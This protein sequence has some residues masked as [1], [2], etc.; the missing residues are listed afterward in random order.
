MGSR[1][2][3]RGSRLAAR[4]SWLRLAGSHICYTLKRHILSKRLL[5]PS[6]NALVVCVIRILH[7]I[8]QAIKKH[9]NKTVFGNQIYNSILTCLTLTEYEIKTM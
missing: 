8:I 1:L 4:G 7:E 5:K 3:A 9:H 2:A 6:S